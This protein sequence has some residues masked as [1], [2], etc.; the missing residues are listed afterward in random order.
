MGAAADRSLHEAVALSW[1]WRP[2]RPPAYAGSPRRVSQMGY[3]SD[4]NMAAPQWPLLWTAAGQSRPSVPSFDVENQADRWATPCPAGFRPRQHHQ[5]CDGDGQDC[6]SRTRRTRVS[7]AGARYCGGVT[8]R[9]AVQGLRQGSGLRPVFVTDGLCGMRIP[10]EASAYSTAGE[11]FAGLLA[12]ESPRFWHRLQRDR[13][14]RLD[15]GSSGGSRGPVG[16]RGVRS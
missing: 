7:C 5:G 11:S 3:H 1:R 16:P 4:V 6:S 9:D 8:P 10:P 13:R 15:G 2:G 12:T 14:R